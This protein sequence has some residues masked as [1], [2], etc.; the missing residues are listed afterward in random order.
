[1]CEKHTL[2]Y[3]A[4]QRQADTRKWVKKMLSDQSAKSLNLVSSWNDTRSGIEASLFEMDQVVAEYAR[5]LRKM[6]A[7]LGEK[8]AKRGQDA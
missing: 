3:R 6:A 2:K 5:D 7:L 1:M 4:Y 8:N